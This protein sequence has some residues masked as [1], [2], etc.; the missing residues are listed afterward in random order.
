M[1]WGRKVISVSDVNYLWTVCPIHSHLATFWCLRHVMRM[2]PAKAVDLWCCGPFYMRD[3][4]HERFLIF[5]SVLTFEAGAC[6][7]S[8]SDHHKAKVVPSAWNYAVSYLLR[9]K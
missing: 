8:A 7:S 9:T 5:D 2:A 3:H 4:R 6:A 1:D